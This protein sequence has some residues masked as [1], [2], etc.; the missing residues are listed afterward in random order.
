[1]GDCSNQL[2]MVVSPLA[3]C[4]YKH[5]NSH[6]LVAICN[7]RLCAPTLGQRKELGL[8]M[9]PI[10]SLIVVFYMLPVINMPTLITVSHSGKVGQAKMLPFE[11][12]TQVYH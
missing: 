8:W 12:I 5:A 10:D 1:M 4:T 6:R 2:F 11:R 3:T 7:R 9:V